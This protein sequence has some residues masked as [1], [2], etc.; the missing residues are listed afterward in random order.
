MLVAL[1]QKILALPDNLC[2]RILDLSDPAQARRIL[3]ESMLNLLT[4]LQDL[5]NQITD[6]N[7]L[8]K[9]EAGEKE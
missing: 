9:V 2:R 8:Q 1:R 6:P 7:W 5:P 3:R 4:E